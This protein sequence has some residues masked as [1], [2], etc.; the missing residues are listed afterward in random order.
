ML[1]NIKFLKVKRL[2]P[3]SE[4]NLKSY[5]WEASAT[6]KELEFVMAPPKPPTDAGADKLIQLGFKYTDYLILIS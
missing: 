4:R 2:K 6:P 1:P 3:E 5:Q